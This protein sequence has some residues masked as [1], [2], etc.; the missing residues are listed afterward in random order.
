[1]TFQKF[2][3]LLLVPLLLTQCARTLPP[4]SPLEYSYARAAAP[5]AAMSEL[6]YKDTTDDRDIEQRKICND[7]L[8]DSGWKKET[9]KQSKEECEKGLQYSVWL[10]RK[11]TPNVLCVA[12]RGTEFLT[13]GQDMVS[14]LHPVLGWLPGYDQYEHVE[15][16]MIPAFEKKY[17]KQIRDGKLAVV[18]TGHS[19]GGGLAQSFMYRLPEEVRQCYAFDPSPVTAFT[20]LDAKSKKRF[21]DLL[22]N[23]GFPDA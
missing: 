4:H 16:T 15:H 19:L 21:N 5:F 23:K 18:T 12:F 7:F 1:M 13:E 2:T 22:P 11:V 20:G 3:I 9:F 10:N 17:G 6:A 8:E 14:N